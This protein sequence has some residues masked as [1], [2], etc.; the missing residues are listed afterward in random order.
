MFDFV[1]LV[2]RPFIRI[3]KT[4]PLKIVGTPPRL[5]AFGGAEYLPKLKLMMLALGDALLCCRPSHNFF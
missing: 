5:A 1:H 2:A 4:M 3:G